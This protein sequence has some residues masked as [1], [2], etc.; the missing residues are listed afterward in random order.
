MIKNTKK[1]TELLQQLSRELD[2]ENYRIFSFQMMRNNVNENELDSFINVSLRTKKNN[3]TF[4]L[5][6]DEKK[7]SQD[8]IFNR[9]LS[10]EEYVKAMGG[11]SERLKEYGFMD[12]SSYSII[13]VSDAD[14]KTITGDF[15]NRVTLHIGQEAKERLTVNFFN[16]DSN[17]WYSIDAN[18]EIES[19]A[20]TPNSIKYYLGSN[21]AVR[22]LYTASIQYNQ[23]DMQGVYNQE[24]RNKAETFNFQF[25]FKFGG[26]KLDVLLEPFDRNGN[27]IQY[28]GKIAAYNFGSLEPPDN[29]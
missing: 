1:I 23:E 27:H 13:G 21:G 17:Q 14:L 22:E 29:T 8:K 28:E 7:F 4:D 18:G 25:A 11:R 6:F 20:T 9:R 15:K 24:L 10:Y 26:N 16:H 19:Q 5:N 3:S 12:E 2:A